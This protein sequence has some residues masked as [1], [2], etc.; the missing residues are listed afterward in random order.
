MQTKTAVYDIG[1]E[2]KHS[3]RYEERDPGTNFDSIV[4]T[5]YVAKTALGAKPY[6]RTLKLTLEVVP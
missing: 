5:L 6:P 4:R 3:V 2:K 1:E